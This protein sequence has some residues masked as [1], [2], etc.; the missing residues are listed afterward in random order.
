MFWFLPSPAKREADGDS[1]EGD[2]EYPTEYPHRAAILDCR[3]DRQGTRG[4][5]D[6]GSRENAVS[7]RFG[8]P[9]RSLGVQPRAFAKEQAVSSNG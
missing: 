3:S 6:E 5:P 2:A 1:D 8:H 7:H 4:D 9:H